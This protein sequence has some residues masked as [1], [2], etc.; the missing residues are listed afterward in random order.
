MERIGAFIRRHSVAIIVI[1][2]LA[3][4]LFFAFAFIGSGDLW[5]LELF[6]HRARDNLLHVY[7]GQGFGAGS[8]SYPPG[9]LFWLVAA[10]WLTDATG[11]A[12][13]STAQLPP[14]LADVGIALAVYVYLGW[15]KVDERWRLAGLATVMLG[16][17]FIAISGYDGQVDSVAML[18]AVLALMAWERPGRERGRAITAGALIGLGA[19]IKTVPLLMILP[20]VLS[21]NRWRERIVLVATAGAMF[22]A[23]VSPFFVVEPHGVY[24]ALTYSG[25]PGRGGLSVIVDP[26]FAINKLQSPGFEFFGRQHNGIEGWLTANAAIITF[27]GLVGLAAFLVRYRPPLIDGIVLLWLV[28]F[29]FSPNFYFQYLIWALPFLIMAGYIGEMAI[30]QFTLIPPILIISISDSELS[31]AAPWIYVVFMDL[32]WLFWVAALV[33]VGRRAVRQWRHGPPA[34]RLRSASSSALGLF[35]TSQKSHNAHERPVAT[36]CPADL[37]E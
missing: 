23:F 4:R 13:S 14:I 28:I 16:P 29:V 6:A 22:I 17:V 24:N 33:F 21:T 27:L 8:Y 35:G 9:Y 31:S 19:A 12:F 36:G 7:S 10:S 15:R 37:L 1:A 26:Q 30:L 18:P 25:H 3:I 2:G 5:N 20:F 32:L 34:G 11:V